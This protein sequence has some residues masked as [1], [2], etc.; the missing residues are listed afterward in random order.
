MKREDLFEAVGDLDEALLDEN[1]T[2]VPKTRKF[3]WVLP[4]AACL[5]LAAGVIAVPHVMRGGLP[6]GDT[7]DSPVSPVSTDVTLPVPTTD[8]SV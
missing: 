8:L 5:V 2:E 4:V 7:P 1:V 6:V 3:R